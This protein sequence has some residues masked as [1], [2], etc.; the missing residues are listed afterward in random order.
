L[1]QN[2][3]GTILTPKDIDANKK[4][5]TKIFERVFETYFWN[6]KYLGFVLIHMLL[7]AIK[8]WSNYIT[9]RFIFVL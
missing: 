8:K 3:T 2:I 7:I 6:K 5:I 4:E 1:K 9:P